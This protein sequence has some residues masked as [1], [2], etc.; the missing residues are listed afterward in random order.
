M[1]PYNL[2]LAESEN[3]KIVNL[4]IIIDDSTHFDALAEWL[5]LTNNN[6]TF[7]IWNNAEDSILYN[8]TRIHTL[9]AHGEVIPRLAY[10]QELN[11]VDRQ[12]AVDKTLAKYTEALGKTPMGIY[13]F[14]PDTYTAQYLQKKGLIYYQGYCFD[15]YNIDYMTMRGGFQMPYYASPENVLIPG[16][17]STVI[18]PHA[19]WDWVASF[20]VTHNLQLHPLNLITRIFHSST[21][22]KHIFYQ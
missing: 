19:S 21:L 9:K 22:A 20:Q 7:C 16:D 8:E 18:L 12:A 15:Q 2:V 10:I 14:I 5:N 4:S 17:N 3:K 6:F 11:P 1:L 13:D